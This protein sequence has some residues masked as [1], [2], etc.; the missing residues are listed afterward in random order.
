MRQKDK[1]DLSQK[2]PLD[3]IVDYRRFL[4]VTIAVITIILAWHVPSLEIDSTLKSTIDTGS[5]QYA[6]YERFVASFGHE[7]FMLFALKNPLG[8][9][10]PRVL[11]GL[12]RI[13]EGMSRIDKVVEVVSLANLRMFQKRNGLLGNFPVLQKN[14]GELSLP[15]RTGLEDMKKALPLMDLLVSS[16]LKTLGILVRMD[17]R[18][19]M[20]LS[21][22]QAVIAEAET[23]VTANMA[24]GTDFRV[25]G[26]PL[27]RQAIVRYNVQTGIIFGILCMLIGTV[28]SAYVFKSVRVTAITN[29]ILVLCILWI[30]GLMAVLRI[31]VNSTTVLSLGFIP[32][33]T[34]EIVIHMVVRYHLYHKTT[35]DKI[36]AIKQTVRWL[37]RP[38]LICSSTT[39]VGFG[40]LMVSSIPMV[41]QL[42]FIMGVGIL[43]C[44]SLTMILTPAFFVRLKA[45]DA[46]ESH[47]LLQDWLGRLLDRIE[48]AIFSQYRWFVYIGFLLTAVLFAGTPFIRSDT[49]IMSMLSQNTREL[50]D[51]R[52]VERNLTPVQYLELVLDAEPDT[53]KKPEVW[54]KV[55]DM[56]DRIKAVPEVVTT[57]SFLSLLH[58]LNKHVGDASSGGREALFTNPDLIPQLFMVTTFNPEG[59]RMLRRHL[60]PG[61]DRCHIAVRIKNSP[62][63]VL[64]D[65]IAQ[66]RSIARDTMKGLART[67]VT[68]EL[69]I[70]DDQTTSLIDDQIRSMFLAAAI[71]VVLMIVQMGSPL[72][73]LISLVPNIPPVAAVFGVMGWCGIPLDSVTVFAACVALGLAVDNTIHFLTQLKNEITLRPTQSVEEGV[74]VAYRLT[75]KQI[76]SW[77]T[78]TL[79]GFLALIV[80]PFKPVVFFGIL[81]CASLAL[82]LYGD[83]VFLQS[84]ILWS[85]RLQSTIRRLCEKEASAM[86]TGEATPVACV[87]TDLPP[88]AA[89]GCQERE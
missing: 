41:R 40:T 33:A 71:I 77:S 84:L 19:R 13:T 89:G 48:D 65:T 58:Y 54:K 79:L 43:I 25:I 45:L 32:I 60:T 51:L 10:N 38:C 56:E 53:F 34:V 70:I 37:A 76:A 26:P 31:P 73:G 59:K 28:V 36:A 72:L 21:A 63:A 69:A 80:S 44:F 66:I 17:D 7:E 75:A 88:E 29:F 39:A 62:D 11:T 47:N 30:V 52:F 74:R 83:L 6:E 22:C 78:I 9:E 57:D 27:I 55:A 46:P 1:L 68:G 5:R 3:L 50:K 86:A 67:E 15:D 2:N 61:F 20:D 87:S 24:P 16:D 35:Q 64:E 85:E 42:G 8:A 4:V 23:I 81:G 14:N 82:C 49:Q 12:V 18:W